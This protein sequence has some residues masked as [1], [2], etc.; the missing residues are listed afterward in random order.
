MYVRDNIQGM[1]LEVSVRERNQNIEAF[2]GAVRTG[3]SQQQFA[4]NFAQV[5]G[6]PAHQSLQLQLRR[7]LSGGLTFHLEASFSGSVPVRCECRIGEPCSE[8]ST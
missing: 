8:R 4:L 3:R 5:C 1:R 7:T 6:A 2:A